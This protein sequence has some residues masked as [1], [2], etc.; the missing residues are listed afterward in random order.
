MASKKFVKVENA[1]GG[2]LMALAS[3]TKKPAAKKDEKE[4]IKVTDPEVEE[5]LN[6]F[7]DMKSKM[8]AAEAAMTQAAGIIKEHGKK[9]WIA[10]MEKTTRAKESFILSTAA[11]KSAMYVVTDA[12]KRA[13]LDEERIDYLK[14]TYGEDIISTENKFVINP[15]LIEVYG[16][17]LCDFIKSSKLI[18]EEDKEQLI[19]LEQKNVITKGTINRLTEIA[20]NSKTSVEAVFEEIQPTCQLK[21]RGK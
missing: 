19:Q 21:A 2:G 15:E 8:D 4:N 18:K 13:N 11:G 7:I 1:A 16:Q 12:Y 10:D 6:T 20:K 5:A 3:K 14:E 17:V 9:I